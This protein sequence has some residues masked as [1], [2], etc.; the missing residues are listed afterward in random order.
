L[1]QKGASYYFPAEYEEYSNFIP[2]NER[3]DLINAYY[4]YLNSSDQNVAEQAAYH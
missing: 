3:G 1:Y 4:K 2:E